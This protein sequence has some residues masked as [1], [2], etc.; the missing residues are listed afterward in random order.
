MASVI[1]SLIAGLTPQQLDLLK[2]QNH[3]IEVYTC[4]AVFSILAVLAVIVRVTSRHMK[5]V[6]VGIDD[7]LV[8]IAMVITPAYPPSSVRRLVPLEQ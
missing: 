3:G 7:V 5:K 4:A 1:A 2:D 8:V 6:A